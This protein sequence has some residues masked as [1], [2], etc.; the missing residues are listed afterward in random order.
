M[1]PSLEILED[2]DSMF[3]SYQI[4]LDKPV[5][6]IVDLCVMH[7]QALAQ[8]PSLLEISDNVI[9]SFSSWCE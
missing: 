9:I 4:L 3:L 8:E 7:A 5:R 6:E 1:K 2:E